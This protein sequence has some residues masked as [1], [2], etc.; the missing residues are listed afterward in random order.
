MTES[1]EGVT[2][3][4]PATPLLNSRPTASLLEEWVSQ[5]D[6][7][8]HGGV[9][10]LTEGRDS[11]DK[12]RRLTRLATRRVEMIS[13]LVE[14][15]NTSRALL[16]D[17]LCAAERNVQV[18]L[19][20]DDLSAIQLQTLLGALDTHPNVEVRVFNP[21]HFWRGAVW[22][23][24]L[25]MVLTGW[26]SHRRMHNKQ[27]L[28]DRRVGIAGG[29][30]MGDDYFSAD[31]EYNFA[32]LD[33]LMVGGPVID[34]MGRC[35]DTYWSSRSVERLATLSAATHD[36]QWCREQLAQRDD[37]DGEPLE[38]SDR[39]EGL[40]RMASETLIPAPARLLWDHPAKIECAWWQRPS[41][42][43]CLTP[44]L[45][46]VLDQVQDELYLVS[47]YFIPSER[48]YIDLEA[49]IRRGVA[50]TALTNSLEGNDTPIVQGGY[51][52]WR[53]RLLRLGARLHELRFDTRRPGKHQR[54]K[55]L[56]SRFGALSSSLHGKA[57]AFDRDRVFIGSYNMD[58]RSMWWNTEMGLL[59]ESEQLNEQLRRTIERS[60]APERS[61]R[62]VMTEQQLSWHWRDR[63]A[64]Q[65]TPREPGS[66]RHRLQAWLGALP[67]ISRLL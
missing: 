66:W 11:L 67:G 63:G 44:Q 7:P 37:L 47:A 38:S 50:L 39:F 40:G 12:R 35:F 57:M 62:V 58:P 22:S 49:M 17:L 54:R 51:A 32:D 31:S 15:G 8:E 25:A 48:D 4:Q 30:N 55:R 56:A 65:S 9:R 52:F 2:P 16:E 42:E 41:L 18:R 34:E 3:G 20:V 21:V 19:L 60:L 46:D 6:R 24:R 28:V 43:Y 64:D 1:E 23:Q 27:W 53:N 33:L 45:A 36:W 26:R 29:R 59:V 14:E 13:Y 61:F 5:H 10:L